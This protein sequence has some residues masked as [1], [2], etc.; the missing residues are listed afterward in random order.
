[1][2]KK[3]FGL[4]AVLLM[5]SILFTGC[6]SAGGQSAGANDSASGVKE[7]P[8]GLVIGMIPITLA[9]GYHQ[10]DVEWC[11][12]YAKEAYGA[13]VKVLDGKFDQATI[14]ANL[15]QLIA[16][17]V[18]A[19]IVHSYEAES[20][21]PGIDAARAAGIPINTFYLE[22]SNNIPFVAIN[23]ATTSFEEGAKVASEWV[24]A[25]PDK[26][27]IY[28]VVDYIDSPIVQSGR[29]GP[30]IEGIK[31]VAPTAKAG[32]IVDGGGTR[33][34]GYKAAQDIIQSNPETNI[35]YGAASDYSLAI[36]SAL[37][38]AGRAKAVDGIAVSELIAGVDATGAELT[39]VYDPTSSYK[40][41]MGLTPKDNAKLKIDT[42]MK[43]W[44]GEID[45][46]K[47]STVEATDRNFNFWDMSVEDARTWY[48]E[49][50]RATPEF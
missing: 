17:D 35:F 43:T 14:V 41:T 39:K 9:N 18:D 48:Q 46:D 36:L 24:K 16:Q 7:I 1:M 12:E 6:Q 34:T 15:D 4:L 20:V 3:L 45:P 33:D 26:P 38:E 50:Y 28:S 27:I 21:V 49:Q 25:Y 8:K 10:A 11:K 40:L 44:S 30:F 32:K 19:I 47:K 13:E 42:I 31:S 22:T 23:E 5:V 2:K 37:E 29:T